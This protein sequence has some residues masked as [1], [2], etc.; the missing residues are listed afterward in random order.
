MPHLYQT[1]NPHQMF[2]IFEKMGRANADGFTLDAV[3]LLHEHL[4]DMAQSQGSP[5]EIDVIGICCDWSEYDDLAEI[6][7]T[8]LLTEV[9]EVVD[10]LDS[11]LDETE[12]ETL[13]KETLEEKGHTVL[14]DGGCC[15][16]VS[17]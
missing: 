13:I 4:E 17:S 3:K 14:H 5:I 7:D 6:I 15:W 10:L 11:P 8:F 16:V 9:S 12:F 1:I 2:A